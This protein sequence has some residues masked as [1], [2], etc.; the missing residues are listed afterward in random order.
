MNGL[1][2]DWLTSQTES[3]SVRLPEPEEIHY[4]RQM[5]LV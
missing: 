4:N 5:K 1:L 2:G 3:F